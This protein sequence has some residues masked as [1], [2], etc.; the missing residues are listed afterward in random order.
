VSDGLY[1][2]NFNLVNKPTDFQPSG[3]INMVKFKDVEFEINT[4][5]P[6]LDKNAEF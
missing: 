1:C 2:Y 3:A 6:E 4:I 5:I